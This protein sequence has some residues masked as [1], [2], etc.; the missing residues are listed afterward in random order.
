MGV[1][2]MGKGGLVPG[3]REAVARSLH[4]Y[5]VNYGPALLVQVI[6]LKVAFSY[7]PAQG[8]SSKIPAG[9]QN[10]QHSG[11]VLGLLEGCF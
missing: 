1:G 7:H 6:N 8:A 10:Q 9:R 3:A 5:K 4:L 2:S 11:R